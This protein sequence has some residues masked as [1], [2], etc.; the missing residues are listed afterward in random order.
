MAQART[1][2]GTTDTGKAAAAAA[3]ASRGEGPP[4]DIRRSAWWW[5]RAAAILGSIF[6][7][8]Q[9]LGIVQS[10]LGAFLTVVLYVIFGAVIAFLAGPIVELLDTR[11]H[12]PRTAAIVLTLLAGLGVVALIGFLIASPIISE[13]AQL[14]KKGPE[15][16]QKINDA[17]NSAR[18]WL[19]AQGIQLGGS[20]VI[21]NDVSGK[22]AGALVT[23]VTSTVTIL[24]DILV[25][26]VVAFWLIKDGEGPRGAGPFSPSTPAALWWVATS[27]LSCSWP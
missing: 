27:A 6:I 15:L 26:L 11:L 14:S 9:L 19:S 1:R 4:P 8:V 13:A 24:L 18:Q 3:P 5:I 12:V 10:V 7:A 22:V 20:G 21:S 2:E 23:I 17:L 16:V 25:T